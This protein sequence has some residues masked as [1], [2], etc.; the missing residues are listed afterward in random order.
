MI[1]GRRRPHHHLD[2]DRHGDGDR[3]RRRNEETKET[4]KTPQ[5]MDH[6]AWIIILGKIKKGGR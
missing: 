6:G 2:R 1:R 5:T 3:D 4:K